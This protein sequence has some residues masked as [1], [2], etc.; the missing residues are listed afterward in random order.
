[1]GDLPPSR[2]NPIRAFSKV[3]VD[4]SGPFQVKPRKRRGIRPMKTYACIFVCFTVKAVHLEM[5]G[6]L[7]SDCFIAALKRF[8]ARRGKSDEIFSDCGTNFI[9]ASKELKAVCSTESVANFLC[10]NEI[11][12]HFNPP[13]A[14][15]FG[16]LWEAA[17]KSMKFHL[18]RAIGAQILIYEE[19]ST[20]LVQIEA[21]LNSRPL[22]PV[23]SDPDDLS[24]ITPAN[25]LI[26]STLD[27]IPERDVTNFTI[28][29]ADRWK[30]V[31]QISQSFWKRWSSEYITQFQ[32]RS[33]WHRP[34]YN[35]RVNDIVLIKDD[36]LPPLKWRMGRVVETFPGSDN[37]VRVV[38]LKTQLGVMKR[39]I[40]KL[41]VLPV[42]S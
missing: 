16:G 28:P 23:S 7:S 21:C 26:G 3:G 39:S 35:L 22:V 36:N 37:Q 11:V 25:F 32:R 5:L 8:A 18:R 33:K 29:L 31:Q 40:H 42:E 6:D 27:A 14:P 13:S 19:F 30:L 12:W 9:G 17:V 34:H 41:C 10:T 15:H 4:L 24:V 2:V 20:L 1:M 38:K